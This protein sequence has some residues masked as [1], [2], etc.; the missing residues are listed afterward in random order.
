MARGRVG[1]SVRRLSGEG[2]GC[3][4]DHQAA[5]TLDFDPASPRS[6]RPSGR[7]R[8]TP[9]TPDQPLGWSGASAEKSPPGFCRA[10]WPASATAS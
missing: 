5:I 4:A 1:I 8:K 10:S 2:V 7:K 6:V 9:S 3:G